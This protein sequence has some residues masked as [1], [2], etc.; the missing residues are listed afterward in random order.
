L[1]RLLTLGSCLS[2]L[3]GK[4]RESKVRYQL[5][6]DK[7]S[8]LIASLERES[9]DP[10]LCIEGFELWIDGRQFPKSDDYWDGNWLNVVARC[11]ADSSLVQ[12]AGPILHLSE[13]HKF[14]IE[15]KQ[16]YDALAG[17]AKLECMEP[18][19]DLKI[20]M[21]NAGRCELTVSLTPDHLYQE[22]SC[23]FD[24]DQSYLPP[25]L[26]SLEQILQAYPLKEQNYSPIQTSNVASNR[27]GV[28][29]NLVKV[30]QTR[31]KTGISWLLGKQPL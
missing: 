13:L 31:I 3:S 18:N 11:T 14:L 17:E 1:T 9:R 30:V 20:K 16:I 27:K 15:C 25:L 12:A 29:K 23:I 21:K 4:F 2:I 6:K 5:V 24:L 10:D 8:E 26:K 28:I 22:H 7:K 19:I